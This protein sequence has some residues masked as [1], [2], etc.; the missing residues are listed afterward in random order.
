MTQPL[1]SRNWFGK[2]S[3][4]LVLGLLIALGTSGLLATALGAT[5]AQFSLQGQFT[6]WMIG[7]VWCLILSFCFLFRD[8]RHAWGVLGAAAGAIWLALFLLGRLA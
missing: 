4:G 1:S 3:A 7:P 2:A 8:A 6:M 5:G